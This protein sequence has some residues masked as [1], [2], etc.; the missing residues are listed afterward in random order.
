[1]CGFSLLFT[2]NLFFAIKEFYFCI[3]EIALFF[4]LSDSFTVLSLYHKIDFNLL[5]YLFP[6]INKKIEHQPNL[7]WQILIVSKFF[8]SVWF[9]SLCDCY[10][11]E[12]TLLTLTVFD[13]TYTQTY[14]DFDSLTIRVGVAIVTFTTIRVYCV[15]VCYVL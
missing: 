1:M 7:W 12:F 15:C 10:E 4:R 8:S 11:T 9:L 13:E 6:S 5:F 3:W 2:R 14:D